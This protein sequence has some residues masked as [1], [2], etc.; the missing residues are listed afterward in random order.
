[1][2]A[3]AVQATAGT[4]PKPE[5]QAE[6]VVSKLTLAD[7]PLHGV[8][9]VGRMRERWPTLS[10]AR[11]MGL[12]RGWMGDN[13]ALLV[14]TGRG[15]MLAAVAPEPIELA[16]TV[17][18]LFLFLLDKAADETHANRLIRAA[19][20]WARGHRASR[21][22]VDPRAADVGAGRLKTLIRAEITSLLTRNLDQA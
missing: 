6:I 21:L 17:R 11:V 10:D 3:A 18:V 14:K 2:A 1:M 5:E 7:L 22:T 13:A 16:P 8:W 15:V 20:T 4:Q 19:E 12:L 9:L